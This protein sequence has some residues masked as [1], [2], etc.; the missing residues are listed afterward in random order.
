M[1]MYQPN[2]HLHH[3]KFRSLVQFH[4]QRLQV[5]SSTAHE[6]MRQTMIVS[7]RVGQQQRVGH[8]LEA[9]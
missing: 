6:E 4:M 9:K 8:P 1:N 7:D 5:L 3:S 2:V